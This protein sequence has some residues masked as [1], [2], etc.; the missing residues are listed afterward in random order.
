VPWFLRTPAHPKITEAFYIYT[1]FG[2]GFGFTEYLPSSNKMSDPVV[3]AASTTAPTEAVTVPDA[4][5]PST[6][7]VEAVTGVVAVPAPAV[8][9]ADNG[10]LLKFAL[11][12]IAEAQLQADVALDDKIKQIVDAIK[13]EIRKADLPPAVRVAAIDWCDDAL[14]YVIK[15]VDMIQAE[16]KKAAL[17]EADKLKEVALV[18]IKKCCPS[19][20]TKKA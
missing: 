15:A 14:P 1:I 11:V 19:L 20:F 13:T 5:I 10:A 16:V 12:K 9:F 6:V 3:P 17:A 8:D 7:T 4:A 2:L 18:E